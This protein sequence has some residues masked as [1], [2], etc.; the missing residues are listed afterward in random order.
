MNP[1]RRRALWALKGDSNE[2]QSITEKQGYGSLL[3]A[4]SEA[5]QRSL[6]AA[7]ESARHAEKQQKLLKCPY[8]EFRGRGYTVHV[9][10]CQKKHELH[11]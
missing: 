2:I 5:E 10:A 1:C 9:R 3:H 6:R 8:C 4:A 7:E 11:V